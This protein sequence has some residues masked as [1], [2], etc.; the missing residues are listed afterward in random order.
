MKAQIVSYSEIDAA[1][2][3]LKKHEYGYKERWQPPE[4][5][6]ALAKGTLWHL[7]MEDHYKLLKAWQGAGRPSALNSL[8]IQAAGI[9]TV[10]DD[11]NVLIPI[12]KALLMAANRHLYDEGGNYV[13]SEYSPLIEWMYEGHL[14]AYGLDEKWRILAVEHG[15]TVRLPTAKGTGSMFWLKLKIDLIVEDLSMARPKVWIV[16]HKSG[17]D[18]PK[19][20][21]LDIDD[22]FGLYTWAM[23]QLGKPVFGSLHNANRT[24]RNKSPMALDDRMKRSRLSRTDRELNRIAVEAYQYARLAY[25][26]KIGEAPR[27]PDPDRCRWRC[28]FTEACMHG[29]KGMDDRQFLV[30]KGY[31]QDFT[32]H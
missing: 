16:D 12:D 18:L 30:D 22:Q 7:V 8:Q 32:R 25:Q 2:Q 29:R 10:T 6:P 21:E 17:K 5:S 28:S 4:T 24:Q 27:S 3:C 26:H 15:P 31:V 1:R 9:A 20:K 14:K 11:A 23:R 13:H 19:D